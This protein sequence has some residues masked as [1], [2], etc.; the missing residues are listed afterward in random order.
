M[1]V[2]DMVLIQSGYDDYLREAGVVVH[3]YPVLNWTQTS[4][5]CVDVLCDG[6]IWTVGID[7]LEVINESR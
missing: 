6:S 7:D 5:N 1:R 4:D 2:G 3:I